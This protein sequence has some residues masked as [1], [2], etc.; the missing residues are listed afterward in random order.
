MRD[1]SKDPAE[2]DVRLK[3]EILLTEVQ[4]KGKASHDIWKHFQHKFTKVTELGKYYKFFRYLLRETI[5]SCVAQ[6]VFV[7]ELRH[8]SGLLFNEKRESMSLLDELKIVQEVI[9]ET[10]VKIPHFEMMLVIT[11]LKIVGLSHIN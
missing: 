7:I 4:T 8:I 6:N 1:W 2:Y 9:D 11:G 5:D 3:N 10:K